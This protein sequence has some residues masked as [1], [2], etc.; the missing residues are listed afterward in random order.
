MFL[1]RMNSVLIQGSLHVRLKVTVVLILNVLYL[2]VLFSNFESFPNK[3]VQVKGECLSSFLF[4][5]TLAVFSHVLML[6]FTFLKYRYFSNSTLKLRYNRIM[7]HVS[8][9]FTSSL[10][11]LCGQFK[12]MFLALSSLSS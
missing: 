9:A 1:N 2:T 11:K 8:A 5:I 7:S 4:L 6:S 12:N 10:I 3:D